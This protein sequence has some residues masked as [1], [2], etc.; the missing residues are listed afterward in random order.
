M[1]LN[2]LKVLLAILICAIMVPIVVSLGWGL[3]GRPHYTDTSSQNIAVY[4]VGQGLVQMELEEYL[5]GV[6]AAEM[7]A[8]FALEA[9]KAQAV[10]ARTYA[11]RK[12]AIFGGPGCD[13]H[14]GADI[15]TDYRHGQAWISFADLK[16]K[17]GFLANLRVL[18]KIDRAVEETRGIVATYQGKPIDAIY[19]ANSGGVTEDSEKVWGNYIPYLRSVRTQL[20][21]AQRTVEEKNIPLTEL[22]RLL[23]TELNPNAISQGR[24]LLPGESIPVAASRSQGGLEV[25]ERSHTGRVVSLAVNGQKFRGID[26][27]SRLGLK[28]ANFTWRLDGNQVTFATVGNGHGIGMC[29]Y[30]ANALAKAGQS[31][32]EILTHYYTGI[33]LQDLKELVK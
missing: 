24:Q 10:A 26:F 19:H 21:A 4:V 31:F 30:G 13:Q 20:P 22:D 7:P 32:S 5:K 27:R 16:D 12:M 15:C 8:D 29:Q 28:S 3:W 11:V 14:P 25:L 6:V 23:G 18:S 9:L 33:R 1:R 2:L 17:Y